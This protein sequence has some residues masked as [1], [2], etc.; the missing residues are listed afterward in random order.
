V[1]RTTSDSR[2]HDHIPP[3][4]STMLSSNVKRTPELPYDILVKIFVLVGP[5]TYLPDNFLGAQVTYVRI[6]DTPKPPPSHS[7][8]FSQV[9]QDWRQAA[10]ATPTLWDVPLFHHSI[11]GSLML[12]RARKA[13]LTIIWPPHG[14]DNARFQGRGDT[15]GIGPRIGRQDEDFFDILNDHISQ[16]STLD[17][18]A[19]TD[20]F[21]II[22]NHVVS[23]SRILNKLRL[24]CF[25]TS[26]TYA[27]PV[28]DYRDYE[29]Y[30][31]IMGITHLSFVDCHI[32][33]PSVVAAHL[34][35]L[36]VHSNT[37]TIRIGD[38]L[39]ILTN[40]K[41]LVTLKLNGVRGHAPG[42]T[43]STTQ[44]IDFPQL[45]FV[46]VSGPVLYVPGLLS[47]IHAPSIQSFIAGASTQWGAFTDSNESMDLFLETAL[48]HRMART[49]AMSRLTLAMDS[50][51]TLSL[52]LGFSDFRSSDVI[53]GFPSHFSDAD[54]SPTRVGLGRQGQY[55]TKHL[56][57]PA[58]R[59][60]WSSLRILEVAFFD[61]KV[62]GDL[63]DYRSLKDVHGFPCAKRGMTRGFKPS[64]DECKQLLGM[65]P[66]LKVL[67]VFGDL[68][69]QHLI[70]ALIGD[71]LPPAPT[72]GERKA[73]AKAK[74][75]ATAEPE[76]EVHVPTLCLELRT[77]HLHAMSLAV[78][79]R[80]AWRTN[81]ITDAL[82]KCLRA[83]HTIGKPIQELRAVLAELRGDSDEEQ[84]EWRFHFR[85]WV[86][87]VDIDVVPVNTRMQPEP[88][89][90]GWET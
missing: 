13:P 84:E 68:G 41:A 54:E 51:L 61:P 5:K 40:A 67:R 53:F 81:P 39:D 65:V 23:H 25:N 17:L 85:Q 90:E 56:L 2:S 72:R 42:F 28:L 77:L 6:S 59:H 49:S 66:Q 70:E 76:L 12:E 73:A 83:R 32:Q 10:L 87:D 88:E 11:L 15:R 71:P 24:H 47:L 30:P 38:I 20:D 4:I 89:L 75:E 69:G 48:Q 36:Y 27:P 8:A 35:T 86:A 78:R 9:C 62:T 7:F 19:E 63:L 33:L 16:I 46:E 44:V 22:S 37:C 3:S 26:R 43:A 21:P 82:E 74:T 14:G 80:V 18:V 55:W 52:G 1:W 79:R 45:R 58:M 29:L 60:R 57:S 31:G 34:N 64:I 50:I